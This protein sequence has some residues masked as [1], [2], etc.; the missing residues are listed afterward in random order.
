LQANAALEKNAR[1]SGRSKEQNGM[2]RLKVLKTR[3]Q[4]RGVQLSFP[5]LRRQSNRKYRTI[6]D[7]QPHRLL[8][9]SIL[10]NR[11]VI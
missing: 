2:V 3:E 5:F 11:P 9:Q 8:R 10:D 7:F 6:K 1:L 4:K